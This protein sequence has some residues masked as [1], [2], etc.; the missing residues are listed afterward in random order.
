MAQSAARFERPGLLSMQAT[1]H[2]A[3]SE[4]R[5]DACCLSQSGGRFNVEQSENVTVTVVSSNRYASRGVVHEVIGSKFML[6]HA[7]CS[8]TAREMI[9]YQPYI[10]LDF[11]KK[12]HME[13][14]PK[15][16]H[17]VFAILC[18][19]KREPLGLYIE[20]AHDL[21]HNFDFRI[22]LDTKN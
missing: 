17:I 10:K 12:S 21:R 14:F 9:A 1:C 15:S 7:H 2:R 6:L 11:Q 22:T 13:G 16:S 19:F 4:A 20:H 18:K 3:S 5:D 8:H